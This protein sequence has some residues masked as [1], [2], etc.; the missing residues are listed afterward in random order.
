[1]NRVIICVKSK[2][3]SDALALRSVL[4]YLEITD[5]RQRLESGRPLVVLD[6]E[7]PTRVAAVRRLFHLA[8][9][10]R[11]HDMQARVH[12]LIDEAED[13][14]DPMTQVDFDVLDIMLV[15]A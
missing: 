2:K 12:H 15:G 14:N 11:E 3:A 9:V 4:P 1:M 8:H 13:P 6:L 7:G 5:L 10:I